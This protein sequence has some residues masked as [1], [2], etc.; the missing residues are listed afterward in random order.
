MAGRLSDKFGPRA[1]IVPGLALVTTSLVPLLDPGRGLQ[2]LDAAARPHR[3]RAGD[4]DGDG[5]D[6][7]RGD[8]RSPGRQGRR[9]RRG[10]QLDAPGRRI[11]GIALTG[12]IVATQFDQSHPNP[13]EFVNGFQLGLRVSAVHSVRRR[14]RS[15]LRNPPG[16]TAPRSAEARDGSRSRVTRRRRGLPRRHKTEKEAR[17]RQPAAQ[18]SRREESEAGEPDQ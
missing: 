18:L 9:R 12:A 4:G 16:T 14:P 6:D 7:L 1:L 8:A 3:R 2:L 10:D 5:A 13:T 15:S 11:R 17:P